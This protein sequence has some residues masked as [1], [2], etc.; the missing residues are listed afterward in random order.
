MHRY[1]NTMVRMIVGRFH[2]RIYRETYDLIMADDLQWMSTSKELAKSARVRV[3]M[4][5][6]YFK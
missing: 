1:C 3:L 5:C 6:Y 4:N 2:V